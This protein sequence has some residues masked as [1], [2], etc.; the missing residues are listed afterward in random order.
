MKIRESGMPGENLWEDF[1]EPDKILATMELNYNVV[2]VADFG[3]GYGTFTIPASKVIKGTIY[4]IE[5]EDEMI[6]RVAERASKEKL[7][8]VETMLCDF[9]YEGSGLENESVDYAMLFNILHA[10]KPGELLKEAYRILTPEGKLGIYTLELRSGNSARS[11]N[12]DAAQ[13]RAMRQMGC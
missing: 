6:N 13:S 12:D 4:A 7:N 3:C 8:N 2:N 11:T 9:I 10:E 5:I 1:F